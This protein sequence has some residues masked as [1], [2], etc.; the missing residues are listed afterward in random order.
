[1]KSNDQ[2]IAYPFVFQSAKHETKSRRRICLGI[3]RKKK[4][5]EEEETVLFFSSSQKKQRGSETRSRRRKMMSK[6]K[7]S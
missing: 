2:H 7:E 5:E 6:A 1:M 4:K 3:N